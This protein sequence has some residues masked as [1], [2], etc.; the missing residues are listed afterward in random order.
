[1]VPWQTHKGRT[2]CSLQEG[3]KLTQRVN[4]QQQVIDNNANLYAR[5]SD[6]ILS[7]MIL[8]YE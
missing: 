4:E 5:I 3:E 7:P 8:T 1:M 6:I 2:K